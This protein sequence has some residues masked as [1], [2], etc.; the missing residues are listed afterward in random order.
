MIGDG[1]QEDV[2]QQFDL[3]EMPN[4]A[5]WHAVEELQSCPVHYCGA[6]SDDVIDSHGALFGRIG[7]SI[8]YATEMLARAHPASYDGKVYR[9]ASGANL[10]LTRISGLTL[11][12]PGGEQYRLIETGRNIDGVAYETLD[13]ADTYRAL[14]DAAQVPTKGATCG[15]SKNYGR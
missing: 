10:V 11:T 12:L 14:I 5:Y 13:D 2:L 3:N 8:F 1:I 7:R 15:L 9:D 6:P 4:A